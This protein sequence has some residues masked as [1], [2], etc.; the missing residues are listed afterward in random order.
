MKWLVSTRNVFNVVCVWP[1]LCS[2]EIYYKRDFPNPNLL[3]GGVIHGP[4]LV[5]NGDGQFDYDYRKNLDL[6]AFL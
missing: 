5:W 3:E 1:L 4:E 2:Y 6:L